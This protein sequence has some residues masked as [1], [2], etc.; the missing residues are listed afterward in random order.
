MSD[1]DPERQRL[2][3]DRRSLSARREG[4]ASHLRQATWYLWGTYLA[5]RQWGT[6]REDYSAN[7]AVWEIGRAHV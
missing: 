2:E 7:G 6:V 5:E 1:L 4:G 3:D